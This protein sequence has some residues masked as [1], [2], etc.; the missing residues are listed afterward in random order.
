MTKERVSRR[1]FLKRS[2]AGSV[3]VTLVAPNLALGES[4]S[5]R[6]LRMERHA[7]FAA[8][9]DTLIPTDPGDPG[10]RSLEAYKITEEVM[11]GLT[12]IEDADL[13]ALNKGSAVFFDGRNFLQLTESQR[14]D[15][16]RLII[17]GSRFTNKAQL[18]GLQSVYEQ[19]R[20]RVFTVFYQN[21]PENV[22]PRDRHGVPI[23]R[24]GDKH[25]ITNPNTKE[26][27]TGFDIA[28]FKGPLTW[29]EEEERR[30]KFRKID[31]QE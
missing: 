24:P 13:E 25:Q 31:W 28:G 7:I 29:E 17:D 1:E 19:T 10:Y 3:A 18:K 22:I 15:Y 14:A 12:G 23:L 5:Q 30:A 16:L 26:L 9:G 27:V 20:T 4:E 11:K 8:L 6:A 21:Y 2:G